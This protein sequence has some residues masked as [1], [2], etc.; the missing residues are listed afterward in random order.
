MDLIELIK[1]RKNIRQFRPEQPPKEVILE[2]LEAA[3]WAPNPTNQQPCKFIVLTENKLKKVIAVTE[4]SYAEAFQMREQL[5][6]PQ[7]TK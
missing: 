4:E 7:L 2:C 1:K 5:P 3:S 6:S